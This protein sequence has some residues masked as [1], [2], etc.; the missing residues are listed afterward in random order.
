M[1][2]LCRVFSSQGRSSSLPSLVLALEQAQLTRNP[3][4]ELLPEHRRPQRHS[5][6]E[7][8]FNLTEHFC[9][10][11]AP[12][13]KEHFQNW[14][15]QSKASAHSCEVSVLPEQHL[16]RDG[17]SAHLIAVVEASGPNSSST[18]RTL[19]YVALNQSY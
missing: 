7:K 10:F 19:G 18:V 8:P 5:I 12:S 3:A 1:E 9:D 4:A 6:V 15:D 17:D 16:E 14:M 13:A 2:S 11:A